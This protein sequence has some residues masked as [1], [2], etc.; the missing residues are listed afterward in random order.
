[1][2]VPASPQTRRLAANG[3]TQQVTVSGAGPAVLMLHGWPLTSHTWRHVAPLLTAAGYRTIAPDLRG[4]GGTDRP[5]AGY[6]VQTLAD[7]AAALL[8]A[9]DVRQ[10]FVVGIDLGTPIAWMLAMRHAQR[11]RGLAVME[12]LLGRQPGAERFLGAGAPWWFGFHGVPGLAER[13]L[14]GREADYLGWF[15][16][17]LEPT[18]RAF[19]AQAYAGREALRGGFEHYRAMPLSARQIAAAIE[20]RHLAVPTLAVSGGIIG[21]ALWQQLRTHADDLR[22]QR[23]EACG[24]N[25]PEEQPA[26]L[27]EALLAFFAHASPSHE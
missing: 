11:V 23:I 18:V 1:M 7:D 10:A 19:Y 2:K 16:A 5:A 4:I 21:D 17:A 24:H 15:L 22:R 6:D 13:L 9:L 8:D 14:E 26:A 20:C 25:I 3:I 27:A 12:G